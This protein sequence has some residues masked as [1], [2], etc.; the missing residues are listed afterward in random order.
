[1]AAFWLQRSEIASTGVDTMLVGAGVAVGLTLNIRQWV[2]QIRRDQIDETP[3]GGGVSDVFGE[4]VRGV[5]LVLRTPTLV[6]VF[7]SGAMVSFGLNGVVGWGPTFASRELGWTASQAAGLLGKWGLIFGVLGTL[8]G[9]VLADFL[10][11]YTDAGRVWTVALG[12]LLGGPLTIWLLTIRDPAHF[13]PVFCA[14]FFCLTWY[15]GPLAATIFDVVPAR[16]SATVVGA[17]LLFIHL[18]GDAIALP[19]VGGLS[20][21]FGIDQ[22][23]MILPIV[24]VLGGVVMLGAVRTVAHDSIRATGEFPVAR[25]T[26]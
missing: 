18:A 7:L 22:A 2:R 4:L 23:I 6:Y 17:Y 13:I 9:G 16:I 5:A 3:F 20:D 12:L 24:S 26:G 11:K 25:P 19:L 21:R 1:M 8:F 15:N 10:K 14:A